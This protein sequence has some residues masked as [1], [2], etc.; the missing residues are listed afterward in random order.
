MTPKQPTRLPFQRLD[1]RKLICLLCAKVVAD[2][3]KAAHEKGVEHRS[4]LAEMAGRRA[5]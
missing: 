2:R 1:D 4:A 3:A 5:S